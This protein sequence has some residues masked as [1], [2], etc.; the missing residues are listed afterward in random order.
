MTRHHLIDYDE[1]EV[2]AIMSTVVLSY[3]MLYTLI[4][5][6]VCLKLEGEVFEICCTGSLRRD[7]CQCCI[8]RFS[9]PLLR[10]S[11][12]PKSITVVFVKGD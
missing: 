4:S 11:A 7:A 9:M 10:T 12:S 1:T 6:F 3:F 2:R 8:L 5:S